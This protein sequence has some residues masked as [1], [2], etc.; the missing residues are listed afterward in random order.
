MKR[1]S[2]LML[3]LL[4]AGMSQAAMAQDKGDGYF[5]VRGGVIATDADRYAKENNALLPVEDGF[6]S[7]T[8]GLEGGFMLT[9]YW[10]TRIYYE[11]VNASLDGNMGEAEGSNYGADI[12]YNLP[13]NVYL[14]LGV[15]RLDIG[16]NKD[17]F[18]RAFV[19]YRHFVSQSVAL[20]FE[21]GIQE[22]EYSEAFA[23]IGL[24]WFFGGRDEPMQQTKPAPKPQPQPEPEPKPA[25]VAPADSD[26]DG[27]IDPNDECPMTP[28][29]YSVDEK[30]CIEYENETI[31]REL[32]VEFDIN[33]SKIR[34]N[35]VDDIK[36]MAEFMKEHPQLDITIEGHTDYTGAADY[37][38]WLS[39]RRAKAVADVLIQRFGID[40]KRVKSVGY[41]ETEPKVQGKT[42]AARQANRRIEAELEVTKRNPVLKSEVN[43]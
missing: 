16:D 9:D 26:N 21:G 41:G 5:G 28:A 42:A 22:G 31:S 34:D 36:R 17:S 18:A 1:L 2:V 13:D 30:G 12:I 24:Q 4:G 37:N 33:S 14:G 32:L 11:Y 23:T 10:E 38:Q 29:T 6:S 39:E 27:V 40:P 19:G 3:A 43:K 7:S 25:P 8:V 15:N 20:R 35:K